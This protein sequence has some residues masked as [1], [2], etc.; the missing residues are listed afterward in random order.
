MR[1]AVLGNSGSGKSTLASWISNRFDIPSF[2]LDTV[3]W[4]PGKVAIARAPTDAAADVRTFCSS[5]DAWA[6][7]GCYASLVDVALEYRPLLLF[8]NPGVDRCLENCLSRPWEPHKYKSKQDQDAKL[9]FLL[10]WVKEYYSRTGDMS[11]AAHRA[12]FEAYSGKKRELVNRVD[13]NSQA[14]EMP[15]WLS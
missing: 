12:C 14:S 11:L 4:V 15:E 13:L 10:T 5:H 7:E 9:E 6:V 3:A 8:M 1:V 2:D